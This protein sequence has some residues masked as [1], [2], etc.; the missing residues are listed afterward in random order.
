M[1]TSI[2]AVHNL[3]KIVSLEH[4][5]TTNNEYE[6]ELDSR[7]G[8]EM[9]EDDDDEE[10]MEEEDED[11]IDES[12]LSLSST[13]VGQNFEY[14]EMDAANNLDN[15]SLNSISITSYNRKI[16][17]PPSASGGASSN[18]DCISDTSTICAESTSIEHLNRKYAQK[19]RKNK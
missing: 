12:G 9:D 6:N 2:H 11:I 1:C 4:S 10:D 8:D 18:E 19:V 13:M 7:D 16:V 15:L 14:N 17:Q 5:G 3:I